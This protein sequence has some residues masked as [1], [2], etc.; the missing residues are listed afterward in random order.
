M[1]ENILFYYSNID[2]N[3]LL[4][5]SKT[6]CILSKRI[7]MNMWIHPEHLFK[8]R[9]LR[10]SVLERMS[11]F[12]EWIKMNVSDYD[13]KSQD[14]IDVSTD[15]GDTRPRPHPV[16]KHGVFLLVFD[17][18]TVGTSPHFLLLKDSSDSSSNDAITPFTTTEKCMLLLWILVRNLIGVNKLFLKKRM[19]FISP[20]PESVFSFQQIT[21][22]KIFYVQ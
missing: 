7:N 13:L 10:Q 4:L 21:G 17:S 18:E 15:L 8:V 11:T 9:F 3:C 20:L 22:N 19:V 12:T 2:Q 5:F 1:L 6:S 16:F 14:R